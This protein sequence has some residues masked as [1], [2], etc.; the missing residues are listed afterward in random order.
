MK[1]KL[2]LFLSA[3]AVI[4]AMSVSV[5]GQTELLP[6]SDYDYDAE[7]HVT[8]EEGIQPRMG[9]FDHLFNLSFR[10]LTTGEFLSTNQ[11]GKYIYPSQ[12]DTGVVQ[13]TVG[14]S[15]G[16]GG[17]MRVGICYYTGNDTFESED[18]FNVDS[19]Y[20]GQGDLYLGNEEYY[21]G[22]VKN[23]GSRQSISGSVSFDAYVNW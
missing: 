15:G 19:R 17:L 6:M 21:Y 10:N 14:N 3:F 22:F 16:D 20:G 18:Y 12:I 23:V 11:S 13:A 5:Y 8:T 1:K 4:S 2:T 9:N 7:L